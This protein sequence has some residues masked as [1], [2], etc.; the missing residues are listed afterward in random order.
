MRRIAVA[1]AALAGIVLAPALPVSAQ[2]APGVSGTSTA[3]I[4]GSENDFW[5][6]LR[7]LGRC[8]SGAKFEEAETFLASAVDSSAEDRAFK[9][10]FGG[11]SNVCMRSFVSMSAPRSYIRGALAEG[12]YKKIIADGGPPVVAMLA[13]EEAVR[14]MH[15]FARC[16]VASHADSAHALVTETRLGT[17]DEVRAIRA[18]VADFGPC[19]PQGIEVRIDPPEVRMAIAEA[20]YHAAAGT[21]IERN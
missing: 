4:E 6:L 9:R 3:P 18:M 7:E 13:A 15:G 8:T 12:M 16:Y 5:W 14:D 11:K 2:L 21:T 17:E 20:L 1:M 10:V 19:L